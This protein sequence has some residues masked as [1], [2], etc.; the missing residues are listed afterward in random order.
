MIII[1]SSRCLSLDVC[2]V[3]FSENFD[4]FTL[5]TRGLTR[6]LLGRFYLAETHVPIIS[7]IIN[8][9][10]PA[11]VLLPASVDG[12]DLAA[13]LAARLEAGLVQDCTR[14]LVGDGGISAQKPVFAG[15]CFAWNEWAEGEMVLI[16]CR[17]NVME[18]MPPSEDRRAEVERLKSTCS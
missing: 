4:I 6:G 9:C 14:I 8:R 3:F 10:D 16:S 7:E 13:R 2:F 15:K 11:A 5:M 12:K 1:S 17:P 18:C